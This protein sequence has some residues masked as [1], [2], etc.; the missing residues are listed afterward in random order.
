MADF[1]RSLHV[2]SLPLVLCIGVL[3]EISARKSTIEAENK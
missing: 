1:S 3:S 2:K